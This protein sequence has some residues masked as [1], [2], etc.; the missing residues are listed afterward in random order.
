MFFVFVFFN[1]VQGENRSSQ[2]TVFNSRL[3]KHHVSFFVIVVFFQIKLPNRPRP[4]S[5]GS[6]WSSLPDCQGMSSC[7]QQG[8][9]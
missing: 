2:K 7:G 1:E 9:F 4:C 3:D 8:K 6:K 5:Q